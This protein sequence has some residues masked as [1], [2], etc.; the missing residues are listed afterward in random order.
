MSA[1]FP[2]VA[3]SPAPRV[4]DTSRWE[5]RAFGGIVLLVGGIL[6]AEAAGVGGAG[7]DGYLLA[8]VA[9]ATGSIPFCQALGRRRWIPRALA[10]WGIYGYAALAT[11]A[12]ER[13]MIARSGKHLRQLVQVRP[14]RNQPVTRDHK[15]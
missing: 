4:S 12:P 14:C 6:M 9:L 11:G 13:P 3:R 7:T 5:G 8:M 15:E 1:P 2:D 10:T